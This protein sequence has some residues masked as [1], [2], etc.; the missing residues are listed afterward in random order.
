MSAGASPHN[1]I[2]AMLARL[3]VGKKLLLIYLLDLTAVIF[4]SGILINEKYIAIN[5]A[6]DETRG[7]AYIGVVREALVDVAMFGAVRAPELGAS[8]TKHVAPLMEAEQK[9]GAELGS[10]IPNQSLVAA[11][12]GLGNVGGKASDKAAGEAIARARDLVTRVG[13]Q[14]KMIL[15]PDLDSYYTMSLTMLRYPELLDLVHD[16]SMQLHQQT[17][18]RG[19]ESGDARTRYLILEGRLDAT[20][21]GI[22][23]DFNEAVTAGDAAVKAALSP[24]HQ[25]LS[26]SIDRFRQVARQVIDK[27]ATPAALTEVELAQ[28][29]LLTQLKA[30]WTESADEL[31]RLLDERIS[32]LFT[33]MWWHLGTAAFLLLAILAAVYFVAR[34]IA[35]PLRRLSAVT[36]T[37]RLSG[38]Y[39][40]RA[41]WQS[42]DEIGRLVLGFNSMLAQLDQDREIQKEFAANARAAA[43]QQALVEATPIPMMVT[44]IPGHEVL[45]ANAPAQHWLSGRTTDP[46]VTGLEADVRKRFFQLLA[47]FDVV[48]EFEV[49]WR[50]GGETSWAVLSA[51]RLTYQGHDALL[52]VFSPI[53]HLKQMEQRLELWAKVFEASSEGIMIVNAD[54]RVISVNRA[55]VRTTGYDFHEAV[56]DSPDFLIPEGADKSMFV[57]MWRA[58]RQKGAWRGE[59]QLR[60]RSGGTLPMWLMVSTV[61]E[62]NGGPSHYI[63]TSVDITDRKKSEARITFLAEHDVLTELPNRSLCI[64]RLR[65]AIQQA[66]RT[67][68][69]VAVL[70]ID[71]DRFKT[72]NDS[73]GHHVGDGLLRSVARRLTAAVRAVDTVSRLGGDEF[74]VVLNG[75]ENGAEVTRI[76]EERLLPAI[77]EPHDVEGTELHVACSVGVSMYPADASGID[78]LMRLADVAMYHAKST[79]RDRAYFFSSEMTDH[80]ER[81]LQIESQ[82]RHAIERGELRLHYQPCVDA[83]DGR[84]VGV[85]GLLRWHN[86]SLGRLNPGEFIPIAEEAG[87]IVPIGE[88]VIEAACEQIAAW[89]QGDSKRFAE[90][91][92][93]VNLSAVQLRNSGLLAVLASSMQRHAIPPG[94]LEL[95]I[96]ETTLMEGVE[97]NLQKLQHIRALGIGLAIDDFGTGYSSL[98][99][100]SRFPINKLKIDRSFVHEIL[101]D[102]NNL[103][104]TRLIISL[105]HTLGLKVIAEGVETEAQALLLRSAGCDQFQ[106]F[107]YAAPMAE[108]ELSNWQPAPQPPDVSSVSSAAAIVAVD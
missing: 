33:R 43:A 35:L 77:R 11:L 40:A 23:A 76:V 106:G 7:N 67:E 79:G 26:A 63:C 15:D 28:T 96:T 4:I 56:G 20:A 78:E 80:A 72:I 36:D 41:E 17:R 6:R 55:F 108:A 3:S 95:E 88:W 42:S 45:H 10:S 62:S 107:L 37:V 82:L 2:A 68:N 83:L 101:D 87:L 103:A 1:P 25:K 65:L 14:S 86:A 31:N 5:F 16:T 30:A 9:Y 66:Q 24:G 60:R 97:I 75:V 92:V 98:S 49:C 74:V 51:R 93:S 90:L 8:L 22:D 54:E 34:Q 39:T 47:H 52:T 99:Y 38:D 29:A 12:R 21:K 102:P 44:A 104:I 69:K 73:L 64:E 84:I 81:R 13:N 57:D 53:N 100:L 50:I 71:L 89:R 70:F 18:T 58:A 48:N 32:G 105:G 85:E 27:G 94:K 46:W 91:S 59:V 19:L 61:R